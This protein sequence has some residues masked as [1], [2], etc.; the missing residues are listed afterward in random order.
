MHR[1][2]GRMRTHIGREGQA[3]YA[4]RGFEALEEDAAFLD[5]AEKSLDAGRQGEAILAYLDAMRRRP[6]NPQ[7]LNGLGIIAF[8]EKR[9]VDAYAL[10]DA[11]AAL[12]PLDQDILLNLWQGAQALKREGDA[13]PRLR[14]S[15]ER[16]PSMQ[17]VKLIVKEYA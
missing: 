15:L 3:I 4:N 2:A 6:Q 16:D 12:H 5:R 14:T 17:D 11:A 8:K 9:Y 13:L 1:E 10:F 7:A